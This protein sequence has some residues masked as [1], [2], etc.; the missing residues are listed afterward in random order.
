MR[1]SEAGVQCRC[2]KVSVEGATNLTL[3]QGP[4]R[5]R[6]LEAVLHRVL[7]A[8]FT[9][10]L[11][12]TRSSVPRLLFTI[13]PRQASSARGSIEQI[14]PR[15]P[16]YETKPWMKRKLSR[17]CHV[18]SPLTRLQGISVRYLSVSDSDSEF[19]KSAQR[20]L[21][22]NEENGLGFDLSDGDSKTVQPSM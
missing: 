7:I 17:S 13:N 16:N 4:A 14:A 11:T 9:L 15:L 10:S 2:P 20:Y 21:I 6:F 19:I 1:H 5:D 18:R 8:R 3:K 12:Q 22:M